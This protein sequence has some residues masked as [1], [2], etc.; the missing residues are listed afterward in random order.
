MF[1]LGEVAKIAI[2]IAIFF[3]YALQFYVPMDITWNKVLSHRID[4]K[5][6]GVAQ[7]AMRT[8]VVTMT[9]VVAVVVRK[10]GPFIGLV[11]AVFFSILG[12]LVPSI[13]ETVTYWEYDLGRGNWK[14][15]KNVGL[16]VLAIVALISGSFTSITEIIEGS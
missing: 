7:V 13:V 14:L 5:W 3:T 12:L 10:L 15:W 11:G 1:R 16:S 4:E 9:V 2:A 8:I 6:H